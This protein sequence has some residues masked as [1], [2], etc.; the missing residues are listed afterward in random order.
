[1]RVDILELLGEA[2]R[3]GRPAVLVTNLETGEQTLFF[4][5]DGTHGREL[6]AAQHELAL[7]TLRT[8]RCRLEQDEGVRLFYQPYNPPL[9]LILVGAVHIAQSL[10]VLARQCGFRV[11]LVDPRRAF[12][13]EQR[14]PDV[15]IMTQWP[16]EALQ[17]LGPDTRTAIVTLSHDPK[18]DDPALEGAL[19]SPA[20][21]V[22]ALG[23]RKTH[24]ARLQRLAAAGFQPGQCDR[25]NGPVGLAIGARSPQEI[26][27]SIMAQIIQSLRLEQK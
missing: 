7:M 1:M 20:F 19:R 22:G 3:S 13:T 11:T 23:S 25:I 26:A 15:C 5:E 9:R 12:A 10:I 16:H 4:G 24:Q 17:S 14:F 27:V 18:I 21:Y 2:R 8:D 6:S